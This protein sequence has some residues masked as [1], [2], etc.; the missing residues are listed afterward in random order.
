MLVELSY[1]LKFASPM[2]SRHSLSRISMATLM[3]D[4]EVAVEIPTYLPST[5]GVDYGKFASILFFK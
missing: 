5:C 3:A 4:A 2:Y 1:S